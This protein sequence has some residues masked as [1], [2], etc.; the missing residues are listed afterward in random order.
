MI[1]DLLNNG[2]V[3]MNEENSNSLDDI[4]DD[5]IL[6]YNKHKGVDTQMNKKEVLH[7]IL[8]IDE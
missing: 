6:R 7:S 4:L 1:C 5:I 2:L 8:S 3:I